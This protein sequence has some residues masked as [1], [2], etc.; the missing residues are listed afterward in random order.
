MKSAA[1]LLLLFVVRSRSC[2]HGM[3]LGIGGGHMPHRCSND[4]LTTS[5]HNQTEKNLN[6]SSSVPR[7]DDWGV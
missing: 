2:S 1:S 6:A 3:G 5:C 4:F 7:Q